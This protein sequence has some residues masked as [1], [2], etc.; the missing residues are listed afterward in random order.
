MQEG[1]AIS[2]PL[3]SLLS[4]ES[5]FRGEKWRGL[6]M[7]MIS[8]VVANGLNLT[9]TSVF[10]LPIVASTVFS[11]QIF[12]SIFGYVLD[13]LFA[14]R[15]FRVRNY[16]G[17]GEYN[18]PV[19]Y[20]DLRTR[21]LWLL[22][23]LVSKQFFRYVI[24]IIIDVVLTVLVLKWAI[25][26][27]DARNVLMDWKYRNLLVAVTIAI[28]SFFLYINVLRFEWAYMDDDQ[29]MFNLIVMMWVTIVVALYAA[30]TDLPLVAPKILT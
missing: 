25:R 20:R 17:M 3:G 9:L 14:K 18:G 26:E 11:L 6:F 10:G 2:S 23:S 12:N 19:P 30:T 28:V 15:S 22:R 4:P 13:I 5:A 16:N 21:G 27:L 24:T 1:G 8:N 29:P 7:S